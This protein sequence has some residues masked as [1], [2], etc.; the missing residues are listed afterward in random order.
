MK[1]ILN[2]FFNEGSISGENT[3]SEAETMDAWNTIQATWVQISPAIEE[4][5]KEFWYAAIYSTPGNQSGDF[6]I[7]GR[8]ESQFLFDQLDPVQ[9]IQRGCLRLK[10]GNSNILQPTPLFKVYP[11]KGG[12]WEIQLYSRIKQVFNKALKMNSK[13]TF[14]RIME[15]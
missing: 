1:V 7:I 5:V 8:G 12:N 11:V 3:D 9:Y 14:Q 6:L 15:T 4:S 2:I 10:V 13:N